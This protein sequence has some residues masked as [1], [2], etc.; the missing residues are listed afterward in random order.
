M[1]FLLRSFIL[2]LRNRIYGLVHLKINI[3][4]NVVKNGNVRQTVLEIKCI[5]CLFI[6]Q[7]GNH[8]NHKGD[9]DKALTAHSP[10]DPSEHIK[11][12]K[13]EKTNEPLG[14]KLTDF[15]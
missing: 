5:Y 8:H 13:I 10:D 7:T 15:N 11:I 4:I 1:E 3:I 9:D 2:D 12:I 14:M 6:F